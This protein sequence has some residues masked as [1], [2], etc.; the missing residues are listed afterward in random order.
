MPENRLWPG[1]PGVIHG[2]L[3]DG[4]QLG[5]NGFRAPAEVWNYC[6]M[7]HA[8]FVHLRVHSAY[9][10]S[11]GAIRLKDLAKMCRS[12]DMPAVAVT[13]TNNL[14]GALEFSLAATD[15]GI[16]PIIGCQ[17]SV[18]MEAEEASGHAMAPSNGGGRREREPSVVLLV[19]NPE[20]YRN[21]LQMLKVAYLDGEETAIS[22][23][24][25]LQYNGGLILLTGGPGGPV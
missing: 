18:Q 20:G 25:L 24:T 13:D 10:L 3:S 6:R 23:D 21:L 1:I 14:F 11:E 15:K 17:I 4:G 12:M 9:S 2:N 22:L 8:D 7:S 19:Q 16:Q 5:A